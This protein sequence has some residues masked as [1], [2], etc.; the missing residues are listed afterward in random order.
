MRRAGKIADRQARRLASLKAG[1]TPTN[2]HLHELE[3]DL[4]FANLE[5]DVEAHPGHRRCVRTDQRP[6][7]DRSLQDRQPQYGLGQEPTS[8]RCGITA[9]LRRGGQRRLSWL[10]CGSLWCAS[11]GPR[12]RAQRVDYYAEVIGD[13]PLTSVTIDR[14]AWSTLR[15]RLGRA[16]ADYLRFDAPG[17]AFQVFHS[18]PGPAVDD[19][20]GTLAAAFDK[21]PPGGRVSSSRAWALAR[22][23]QPPSGWT[24]EGVSTMPVEDVVEVA[25]EFG[26]YAGAG[27]LRNCDDPL[28]W[29]AFVLRIG[30][31][32]PD[33]ARWWWGA[34]AARQEIA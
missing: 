12:L 30:M 19:V 2:D 18:G 13:T 9:V 3:A 24:L 10:P 32:L 20:R 8:G 5:R 27:Q 7:P 28:R 1:R 11:C 14:G 21:L 23:D 26:M 4:A 15:R 16:G 17:G 34:Q 33:H 25:R 29:T 31:H 22:M 6:R